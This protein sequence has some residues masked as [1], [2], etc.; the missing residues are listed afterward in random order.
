MAE[1]IIT[2]KPAR[3]TTL[4]NLVVSAD[5]PKEFNKPQPAYEFRQGSRVFYE[6]KNGGAYNQS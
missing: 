6:P 5:G 4:R 3:Q 2:G 1:K